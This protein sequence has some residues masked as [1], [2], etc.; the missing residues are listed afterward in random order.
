MTIQSKMIQKAL[1]DLTVKLF[2]YKDLAKAGVSDIQIQRTPI[3]TRG[4]V[5]D[6]CVTH[7]PVNAFAWPLWATPTMN[8][9]CGILRRTV[10]LASRSMS[11]TLQMIPQILWSPTGSPPRRL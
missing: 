3:A 2:L 11:E 9:P 6:A 5:K 1:A 7:V 8:R 10:F 4:G